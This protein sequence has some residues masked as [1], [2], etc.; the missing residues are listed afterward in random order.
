MLPFTGSA[1][2]PTSQPER[3]TSPAATKHPQAGARASTGRCPAYWIRSFGANSRDS[4]TTNGRGFHTLDPGA[5]DP[6]CDHTH[7]F[8]MTHACQQGACLRFTRACAQQALALGGGAARQGIVL[9]SCCTGTCSKDQKAGHCRFSCISYDQ[10][11]LRLR[12][13]QLR[14]WEV[15]TALTLV[16]TRG[17]YNCAHISYGHGRLR[18]LSHQLRPGEVILRLR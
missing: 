10:G 4:G 2:P 8:L 18:L 16:T 13:H 7:L 1:H 17:G 5:L 9:L 11:K 14:P 12:S 6:D 15:T 3:R